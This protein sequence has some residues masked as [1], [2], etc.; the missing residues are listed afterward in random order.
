MSALPAA[1]QDPQAPQERPRVR[2]RGIYLIP[3]SFTVANVFCGFNAII[4][5]IQGEYAF[6]AMLIGIAILLDTL[7]GRVARFANASSDFG[8][9]FDS[10]ADQVSFGVAPMVLAYTWGL[11]VWPRLG[12]LMGFLFVICGAMRLARF[13]IQQSTTDKRFFVGLPIPAAAG[14]VAALVYRF[15]EPLET[16][17]AAVPFLG[18]VLLLSFLM[19]SKFR[20]YSF[21]DLDLRRRQPP[22]VILFL[23]LVIVAVFTHPQVMLLVVASTYVVHGLVLKLWSV[24][25]RTKTAVPSG[26][27]PVK[28]PDVHET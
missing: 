17:A 18:L 24:F 21:K 4:S 7:D 3:S 25:S 26:E 23:A 11:H 13:N 14:M 8:K 5:S 16:R 19:V 6:A 15:A 10:L 12:W 2:R 22:L 1:P 28:S 27:V 20:Y 9:E